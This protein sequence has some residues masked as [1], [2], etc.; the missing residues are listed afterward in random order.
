MIPADRQ[1][2]AHMY[3][4]LLPGLQ[5]RSRLIARLKEAG[6]SAVFH[7]VPLH[8][9]EAGGRWGRAAGPL[10]VTDDVSERLLRLPLWPD[11]TDDDV[12]RVVSVI[13]AQL[14]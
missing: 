2:N 7:Y 6:A 3:Y 5:A 13:D 14:R 10:S 4:V 11:M 9:S 12:D 8:S 1:A